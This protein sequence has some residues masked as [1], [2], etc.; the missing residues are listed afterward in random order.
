MRSVPDQRP[1]FEDLQMDRGAFA[2]ARC[3][4]RKCAPD[5]LR[6][7]ARPY[8][9]G[10]RSKRQMIGCA[11]ANARAG[12]SKWMPLHF[13]MLRCAFANGTRR[14]SKWTSLHFEMIA[15]TFDG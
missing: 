13:E 1:L 6:A 15:C 8:R 11:F 3:S 10:T 14:A 4:A 12:A 5:H 7:L 9:N 2:N